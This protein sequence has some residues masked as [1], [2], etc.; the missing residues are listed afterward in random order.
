MFDWHPW[1]NGLFCTPLYGP[2]K[3]LYRFCINC[4]LRQGVPK[5]DQTKKRADHKWKMRSVYRVVE[6]Q[7]VARS[8][9]G[10]CQFGGR[11]F[12]GEKR[13]NPGRRNPFNTF[14]NKPQNGNR[15]SQW[16]WSHIEVK[17][18]FGRWKFYK[19]QKLV[20]C[21]EAFSLK[22]LK[23]CRMSF[24]GRHFFVLRVSH[25]FIVLMLG[26]ISL[27]STEWNTEAVS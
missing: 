19:S 18:G 6:L 5:S 8:I 12:S 14:V 13:F 11:L 7:R 17:K 4:A 22:M 1:F 21:F 23:H 16:H 9:A 24:W 27:S 2:L 10:V 15:P 26:L 20:L 3:V 25:I